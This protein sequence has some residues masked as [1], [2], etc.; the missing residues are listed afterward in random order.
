[1]AAGIL[2]ACAC[3][4]ACGES[5]DGYFTGREDLYY[6]LLEN[7]GGAGN[8]VPISP[9]A[10]QAFLKAPCPVCIPAECAQEPRAAVRGGTLV[11]AVADTF[12]EQQ[13]MA[14]VFDWQ[15]QP[16]VEGAA[17]LEMLSEY[18]NGDPYLEFMADY[19]EAD[20]AEGLALIP[21][22]VSQEGETLLSRRHLGG[23]WYLAL[24]T[25]TE[26][27]E[28]WTLNWQIRGIGLHYEQDALYNNFKFQT[29]SDRLQLELE[30]AREETVFEK[31]QGTLSVDVYRELDMN[32]AVFYDQA[33]HGPEDAMLLRVGGRMPGIELCGY[34]DGDLWVSCCVLTDAELQALKR[35]DSMQLQRAK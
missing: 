8:R 29:Q 6:H 13:E 23:M 19:R 12:L 27:G 20:V 35:G 15:S 14:G 22:W 32:I 7:C 31:T 25:G 17:A 10:A 11:V 21:E 2:F 28:R 24:R 3:S 18:L 9:T 26:L 30:R 33:K 34:Q 1:M 16:P 4:T 5:T